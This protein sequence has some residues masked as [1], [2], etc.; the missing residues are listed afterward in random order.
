MVASSWLVCIMAKYS[1]GPRSVTEVFMK[2][3]SREP[4]IKPSSG[5]RSVIEAIV[6]DTSR[7]PVHL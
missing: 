3:V 4:V 1:F 2:E 7:E 6:T 5:L